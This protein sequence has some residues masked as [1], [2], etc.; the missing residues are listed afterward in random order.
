VYYLFMQDLHIVTLN[1][2]AA[3]YYR[4]DEKLRPFAWEPAQGEAL[5]HFALN[6][7]EGQNIEVQGDALLGEVLAAGMAASSAGLGP[8]LPTGRYL[9]TQV[10]E[11]ASRE[12]ILDMAAEQ[13]REGLWQ[14]LIM[15]D[16]LYLRYLY[17]DEKPVTQIFRP[18]GAK[19]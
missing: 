11:I 19:A 15:E 17:E 9:F 14:G 8:E 16:R 12:R 5:F 6:R 1:L 4:R 10:R 13:Q 3:L 2:G 18:L 7:G